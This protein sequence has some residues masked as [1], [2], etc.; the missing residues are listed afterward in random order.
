MHKTFRIAKKNIANKLT[1]HHQMEEG[2]FD[3]LKYCTAV[4]ENSLQSSWTLSK[5]LPS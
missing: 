4:A 2:K 1:K 5:I 3:F